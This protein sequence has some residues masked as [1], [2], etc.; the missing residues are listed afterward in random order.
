MLPLP[1]RQ[2]HRF[3]IQRQS[4]ITFMPNEKIVSSAEAIRDALDLALKRW[5]ECYLMGE[6]VADPGGI[7]GTTKGLV[8]IYGPDRVVEMPVAE[9]GLTGIAIGS[10][11][12]G[13]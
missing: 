12:M 3:R 5:P 9:N 6:G 4:E 10:A 7:F 11:L 2:R 1:M 8:D 13:R